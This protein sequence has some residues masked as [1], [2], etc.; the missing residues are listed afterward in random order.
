LTS[1]ADGYV[2]KYDLNSIY[3]NLPDAEEDIQREDPYKVTIPLETFLE[4]TCDKMKTENVNPRIIKKAKESKV[5]LLDFQ[6]KMSRLTKIEHVYFVLRDKNVAEIQ[7]FTGKEG[8]KMDIEPADQ[9]VLTFYKSYKEFVDQ[10]PDCFLQDLVFKDEKEAEKKK[11]WSEK[12]TD[13]FSSLVEFLMPL[14]SGKVRLSEPENEQPK[15]SE[16]GK[17]ET[18]EPEKRDQTII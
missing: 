17:G 12:I 2:L 7:D 15:N 3:Q 6:T 8:V 10:R 4:D 13:R 18:K 1:G 16:E 11:S 9:P 5:V 14:T